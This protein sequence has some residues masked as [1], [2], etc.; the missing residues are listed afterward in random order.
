MFCLMDVSGSMT[1]HMKDLAKRFFML[2]Y[3]FLKRR[4]ETW[5]SSSSA[6]PTRRRRW[7]RRPSSTAPRPAARWSPRLREMQRIIADRYPAADWNIYA[8]QA[9]DGDNTSDDKQTTARCCDEI[10]P[11]CQYFAYLEVGREDS[12]AAGLASRETTLWQTYEPLPT[13]GWPLAMRKVAPRRDLPG[14]PRALRGAAAPR[15]G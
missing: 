5:T 2:L 13:P 1:E 10:L 9:S 4:Y 15:G 6:T 14:L 7:T 3:L 11:L 12:D 8:A